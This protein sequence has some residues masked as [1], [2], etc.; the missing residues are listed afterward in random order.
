[1]AAKVDASYEARPQQKH[2]GQS[3]L[4]LLSQTVPSSIQKKIYYILD[5]RG[6]GLCADLATA[7]EGFVYDRNND[8]PY[9]VAKKRLSKKLSLKRETARHVDKIFNKNKYQYMSDVYFYLLSIVYRENKN[10]LNIYSGFYDKIYYWCHR[11]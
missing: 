10:N 5:H 3:N 8:M 6:A 11:G 9:L 4:R 7:A 2:S 1:M